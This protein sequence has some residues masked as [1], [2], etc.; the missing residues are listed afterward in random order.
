MYVFAGNFGKSTLK[1]SLHFIDG[2]GSRLGIL[3]LSHKALLPSESTGI[4][5]EKGEV[6]ELC[7]DARVQQLTHSDTVVSMSSLRL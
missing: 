4:A 3:L 6:A 7:T 2:A 5:C 1:H